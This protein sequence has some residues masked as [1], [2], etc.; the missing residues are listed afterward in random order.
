MA[1]T[2][3]QLNSNIRCIEI[4]KRLPEVRQKVR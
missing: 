3:L 2:N 1:D 4:I